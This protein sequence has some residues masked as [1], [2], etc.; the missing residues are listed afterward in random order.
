MLAYA[1]EHIGDSSIIF[2]LSNGVEIPLSENSV[3]AA[4]ST[5]VFQHF[6]R[7]SQATSYFAE[8]SRVLIPGGSLMIHLPIYNWPAESAFIFKRIYRIQKCVEGISVWFRR[9][10]VA[11]GLQSP[12][13]R[14]LSYPVDYF[15]TILPEKGFTDIEILI[16]PVKSN[17]SLHPFVLARKTGKS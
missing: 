7:L 11:R 14:L 12:I 17:W 8:I 6:D 13:M 10:L 9:P 15:H 5:H 3:S 2:Y 1:R 16:F 4:F